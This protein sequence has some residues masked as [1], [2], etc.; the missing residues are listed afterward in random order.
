MRLRLVR[1]LVGLL[2][3][4]VLAVGF[5]A[6]GAQATQIDGEMETTAAASHPL[7]DM[8]R[9]CGGDDGGMAMGACSA[10]CTVT[11]ALPADF[12]AAPVSVAERI[13]APIDASGV[14]HFG[15]P[16]PYPPRRIV[17]S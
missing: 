5:G 10:V 15:P 17:L 2:A 13:A 3:A 8:C 4:L 11:I 16:E 12:M 7:P 1:R 14:S 9:G 6:H